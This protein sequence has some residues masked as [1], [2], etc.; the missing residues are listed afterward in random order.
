MENIPMITEEQKRHLLILAGGYNKEYTTQ[1][2]SNNIWFSTCKEYLEEHKDVIKLNASAM[3]MLQIIRTNNSYQTMTEGIDKHFKKFNLLPMPEVYAKSIID[4]IKKNGFTDTPAK[5]I[6]IYKKLLMTQQIKL[7]NNMISSNKFNNAHDKAV[8]KCG[9]PIE[10]KETLIQGVPHSTNIP[11]ESTMSI[12]NTYTML[13]IKNKLGKI[14]SKIRGMRTI[15][16]QRKLAKFG[17]APVNKKPIHVH[18]KNKCSNFYDI[19][20][21]NALIEHKDVIKFVQNYQINSSTL[22]PAVVTKPEPL[23]HKKTKREIS[24]ALPVINQHNDKFK[25][26]YPIEHI[27]KKLDR[28]MSRES[29]RKKGLH[30]IGKCVSSNGGAS[31]IYN[32]K[33]VDN[34]IKS[35]EAAEAME[36]AKAMEAANA[37]GADLSKLSHNQLT[38]IS[39]RIS[40]I[41]GCNQCKK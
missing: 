34:L 28:K 10:T 15:D 6:T 12:T 4:D 27:S 38:I 39:K 9:T 18:G 31:F 7:L 20:K 19:N 40:D 25:L 14:N 1:L 16:L 3:Y 32:K 26:F 11:M 29:L 5:R 35:M 23:I 17:L 36:A 30:P 22:M 13:D 2:T 8:F 37:V 21:V 33:D 41:L 24:R